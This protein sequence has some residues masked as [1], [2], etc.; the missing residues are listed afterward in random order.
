MNGD[1]KKKPVSKFINSQ[2]TT[3]HPYLYIIVEYVSYKT[4][5]VKENICV[6]LKLNSVSEYIYIYIYII[7]PLNFEIAYYDD[8]VQYVN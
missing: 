6:Q 4:C 1:K 2:Y 3:K 5:I 8:A 7:A